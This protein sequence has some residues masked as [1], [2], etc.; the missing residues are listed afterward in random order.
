VIQGRVFIDRNG[1]GNDDTDE[2]GLGG[3]KVQID[4]DRSTTTDNRGR[5]RF[6]MNSGDYNVALISDELGL[7]WRASTLTEQRV[8]LSALRTL[9]V[10]FG[11]SDY[12][13]VGG[14]VFNDLLQT[15]EKIAGSLPGVAG[16]RV[17]LSPLN[18]VGPPRSAS[19]DGHGAY[20]FS[21]LPPGSYTLE[22]DRASLPA[23]FHVPTLTSWVVTVAPL[24]NVYL[25]VPLL[26]QRAI[27]GVVFI[28]KDG[29]GKFDLEK[30]EPI[31]GARIV[32]GKTEVATGRGGSYILR[33]LHFGKIE[34]R[35][36]TPWGSETDVIIIEVSEGPVRRKGI[37]FIVKR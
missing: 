28:D 36:R 12:G 14:R 35:A 20:Q 33:N 1:N 22:I 37:N 13:L 7:R 5:F 2:P 16:V 19:V 6:Q 9:N 27:S 21:Q 30:D 24:E 34:V 29:D 3:M 10:S 4:G 26:A 32:T 18:G 31:E 17:T 8:S 11:L 23:D 15:G 25:D